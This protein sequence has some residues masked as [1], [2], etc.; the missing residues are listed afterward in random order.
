M[1]SLLK[2]TTSAIAVTMMTGVAAYASSATVGTSVTN[3]APAA[4]AVEGTEAGSVKFQNDAYITLSGTVGE[5]T[6]GDQFKLNHSGG[7]I[8]VDTNDT[9][10]DLF[11]VDADTL[12]KTGDRIT[13]T[14]KVD[15]N[16]FAQNEIEAYQLTVDGPTYNRVYTNSNFG[17]ENDDSYMA[18]YGSYGAGLSDDQEVRLSGTVSKLVNNESFM[19]RY[20]NGEIRVETDDLEFTNA[21]RLSVGDE[22]VVYGEVDEGWFKKKAVEADRIIL[23]RSYSMITR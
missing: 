19:L 4:A 2:I 5:I 9:W 7:I 22:V 23:S 15:N 11:E 17:P 8:M 1:R 13:V 20:G 12:L 6:D 14:G 3:P 18:Y 10:P 16:L 21:D